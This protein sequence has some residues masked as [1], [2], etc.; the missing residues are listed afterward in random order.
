MIETKSKKELIHRIHNKKQYGN[1]DHNIQSFDFPHNSLVRYKNLECI[2]SLLGKKM[3]FFICFFMIFTI[4]LTSTGSSIL[5]VDAQ[6]SLL[7]QENTSNF[8]SINSS[9]IPNETLTNDNLSQS[10]VDGN[11]QSTSILEPIEQGVSQSEVGP[12]GPAG[13][14]GPPGPAGTNGTN[15]EPGPIGL[16]GPPGPAGEVGPPG[17]AGEVGPPGPAGEVGPPGPAGEV[18]PPG[19]AG[20]VGPP[21]PAGEVGPP[22]PAGEVGPPGP[23]GEVGPPGPAGEVGPPGP[24]GTNGTNGEPGPIGLMGPPGPSGNNASI[25]MNIVYINNG[26]SE[27]TSED[28][29]FVTTSA[30]CN[31]NDIPISGGYSV[32][33]EDEDEDSNEINEIES[34]PNLQNNSWTINVEG[35]DLQVTPY[36]VCLSVTQ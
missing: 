36:V 32:V 11:N 23:A 3:E 17:P 33:K 10:S 25:S 4:M 1:N 28:D 8:S 15:G 12:P 14:V 29:S 2:S 27:S 16:M 21:G 31:E 7:S 35:D 34:I 24:A 5:F 13:E 26:T 19:P 22:G 6:Q 30:T 9:Q 18:G 20:E